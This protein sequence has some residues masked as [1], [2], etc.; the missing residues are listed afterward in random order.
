MKLKTFKSVTPS[1]RNLIQLNTKHL[2]NKPFL[3]KQLK[4][5]KKLTGK[6]NQGKIVLRR[7]GGGHKQKYRNIEFNRNIT[8]TCI[9]TTIEYDPFRSSNIASVYNYNT[10]QYFY[11][12]ASKN[13]KIGDIIKS[14]N[15]AE[16][17]NGHSLS[18]LKIPAGSLVHNVS[19]KTNKPAQISRAAGTFCQLVEKTSTYARIKLSSGKYKNISIN[20]IAT[21]GIVSNEFMFHPHG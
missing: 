2:T 3:K 8:S 18:F 16:I 17:K 9:V 20:C 7:R 13:L 19:L 5:L 6:N 15:N 21:L 11:I 12:L 4:K 14:G 1:Q 10:K